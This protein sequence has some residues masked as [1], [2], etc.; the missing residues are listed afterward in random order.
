MRYSEQ[1]IRAFLGP[2]PRNDNTDSITNLHENIPI[3]RMDIDET[4][5]INKKRCN[6]SGCR[7]KLGLTAFSCK[8]GL[9]YCSEHRPAE[10]H[11]CTYN[12]K[13]DVQKVVEPIIKDK[14]ERI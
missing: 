3:M 11:A 14:L 1:L 6:K 12:Y 13:A 8:C 4:P 7:K 9:Y 2:A 10:E 5:P